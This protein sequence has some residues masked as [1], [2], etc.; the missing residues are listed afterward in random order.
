MGICPC[1]RAPECLSA[2]EPAA[3]AGAAAGVEGVS[4]KASGCTMPHSGGLQR[5]AGA[6][7]GAGLEQNGGA[8][9]GRMPAGP[10]AFFLAPCFLPEMTW[11]EMLEEM[12]AGVEAAAVVEVN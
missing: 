4:L 7:A 8:S 11:L 1:T 12:A 6:G 3:A 9:V 10:K 5:R 2:W